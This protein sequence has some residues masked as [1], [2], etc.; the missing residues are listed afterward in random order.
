MNENKRKD[1]GKRILAGLKTFFSKNIALKI[2]SLAFAVLLW[3]YVMM[4]TDPERTKIISDVTVSFD[5]EDELQSKNLTVQGNRSQL[6]PDVT[7][8]VKAKIT[9]YK[10]LDASSINATVSLRSISKPGTYQLRIY[11]TAQNG[12]VVSVS[13]RE[14]IIEV[15]D[16]AAK[17][18]PINVDFVGT[19]PDS[20]WRGTPTLSS[21]S[22]IV[23]GAAED[24]AKVVKAK[25]P[26][27]LTDR[28][29][30]YNESVSLIL[31][32]ENG[33]TVDSGLFID[34]LPSVVVK[35]DV[36]KTVTLPID[37]DSA[38]LGQDAL[39]TNYEVVDIVATP[40][41]VR[42]AG[43]P[44]DLEKLSSISLE[45]IDV[46]GMSASVLETVLLEVP[47]GVIL[48]DDQEVNLFVDIREKT[49]ERILA[50]MAIDIRNLDRGLEA[51][52][53]ASTCSITVSGRLSLMRQLERGD[54]TAY[55][56]AEGLQAGQ[57]VVPV[58]VALP[59]DTG[60]ELEYVILPQTVTI[61]IR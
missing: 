60:N 41:E 56:D 45:Q 46:S 44:E 5:G 13:P 58:Q 12:N 53:S 39:P 35:M 26:I 38:V 22:L 1:L 8:E 32:D 47:E 42:V 31:L 25:C 43:D 19:L 2:I 10:N 9:D 55:V 37:V 59:G 11:A 24:V 48:L 16:L 18:V 14:V 27:M 49:E 7:V 34:V 40:A 30:S 33:E 29:T 50:D 52:L 51:T 28:T 15:D 21:E 6:L 20:Y 57:H 36:L 61:T 23:R 54:V 4:E 17:T 3:G